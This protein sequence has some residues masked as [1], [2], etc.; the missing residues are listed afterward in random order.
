MKRRGLRRSGV[1]GADML[2]VG[3]GVDG[4]WDLRGLSKKHMKMITVITNRARLPRTF[5][6]KGILIV[7]F[8]SALSSGS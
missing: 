1:T 6:Q 7:A 3:G 2:E 8:D 4:T 5:T